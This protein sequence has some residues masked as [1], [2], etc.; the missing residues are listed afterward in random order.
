M[1]NQCKK[2]SEPFFFLSFNEP[3]LS[4]HVQGAES[5]VIG[6]TE[7]KRQKKLKTQDFHFDIL[8]QSDFGNQTKT[9]LK[10]DFCVVL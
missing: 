7:K 8:D 4:T 10:P 9:A 1:K 2:A 6:L 5:G 3:F